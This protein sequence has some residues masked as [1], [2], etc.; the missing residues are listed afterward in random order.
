MVN[1]L[2]KLNNLNAPFSRVIRQSMTTKS[3]LENIL[4]RFGINDCKISWLENYD[5]SYQGPQILNMGNTDIGGTHWVATYQDK[6]FDSFALPPPPNLAHLQ[7]TPLQFQDIDEG[8]C[9]Q[10]CVLWVYYAKK[11]NLDYFYDE[12]NVVS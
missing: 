2:K 11:N 12:F 5:P 8:R 3:D 9:G 4:H 6:Y 7:W 1:H 10:W